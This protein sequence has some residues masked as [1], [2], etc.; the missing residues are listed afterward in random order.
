MKQSVR[1]ITALLVV[2]LVLIPLGTSISLHD[3]RS[4]KIE[5]TDSL[6]GITTMAGTAL[7]ATYATG[8]IQHLVNIAQSGDTIFLWPKK[9]YDNVDV[10]KNLKIRGSGALW[11]IVDGQQLGSVFT[12][13]NGVTATL[14]GMTIKNGK[15]SFGGG[16][17]N[18]G[19]TE[20]TGCIIRNNVA[21]DPPAPEDIHAGG[22]GNSET[23]I[24]TVKNSAI[25]DNVAEGIDEGWGGG[26]CNH[27][28]ETIINS[29]IYGNH[30]TMEGGGIWNDKT[31]TVVNS[32]IFQN[33]AEGDG[34]GITNY[35]TATVTDSTISKNIAAL[36]GGIFNAG[37]VTVKD[38]KISGNIADDTVA[39][40]NG[41]GIWNGGIAT[42][43]DS[44]ISGNTADNGGGIYNY[45]GELTL[46]NSNIF[47][48]IATAS[49]PLPQPCI[50][51]GGI[52]N[53][54]GE[55]TLTNSKIFGNTGY[56]GGGI[57]NLDGTVNV[58]SSQIYMNK[59]KRDGGG[60]FWTGTEPTITNSLIFG[61][62]PNQIGHA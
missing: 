7:Y 17:Q 59:A 48:N 55:L 22:I 23:G 12:I 44:I 41:G 33:T 15:A 29:A 4:I 54:D 32:L 43:T 6:E 14:S 18:N 5:G 49:T 42:I 61:N 13:D 27:G 34:G 16:I 46:T 57:K 20:V 19:I 45:G 53:Y 47:G 58:I 51:G 40:W 52:Y 26:I 28:I 50:G 11:T 9:Y 3:G 21:G 60:I 2:A 37:I 1:L 38:C 25:F 39:T 30:A 31:L 10:N 62:T 36:G 56:Y 8:Q 35:G 24:L